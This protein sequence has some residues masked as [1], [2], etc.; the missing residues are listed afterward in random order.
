MRVGPKHLVVT[1]YIWQEVLIEDKTHWALTIHGKIH[2][3]LFVGEM[4]KLNWAYLKYSM[5]NHNMIGHLHK[6]VM[7]LHFY[8]NEGYMILPSKG[9]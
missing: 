3:F 2:D 6:E 9:R 4:N 1:P 7:S 8:Q 5:K